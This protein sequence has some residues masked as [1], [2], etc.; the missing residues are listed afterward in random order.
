[1]SNENSDARAALP[2]AEK[3]ADAGRNAGAAP[4]VEQEAKMLRAMLEHMNIVVWSVDARGTYTFQEGNALHAMGIS[5]RQNIGQN[6]FELMDAETCAPTRRALGG[7]PVDLIVPIGGVVW[8]TSIRPLRNERGEIEGVIGISAEVTDREK[9]KADLN[10]KLQL[11]ER[12]QEVIRNLETPILQVWD[13]VLTLP[14]IGIVDSSR[15]ARVMTDLLEAITRTQA[16]FAILDLTGVDVVDT[17]TASHIISLINAIRL[18]GAEGIV[19]GIRPNVAQTIVSLGVD[20]SSI[21][22]LASLRDGLAL[23]IRRMNRKD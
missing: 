19:T 20:L 13:R 6:L 2:P 22:T 1:M 12:Q 11:I 14:M 21:V 17:A 10:A 3:A 16:R 18:V 9:A 23:A 5:P 15:A 7:E 8:E 4:T